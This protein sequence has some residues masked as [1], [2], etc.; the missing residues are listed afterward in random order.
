LCTFDLNW[1]VGGWYKQ[2]ERRFAGC[3]GGRLSALRYAFRDP[4]GQI[5]L[6][7]FSSNSHKIVILR[8]SDYFVLFVFSAYSTSCIQVPRQS[9]HPERSALQI[10]R[11]QRALCAESKDPGDACLQML[12]GAFRP[13]TTTQD[14]K[15]TTSERNAARIY[16]VTQRLWRGVEGPVLSVA[17]GTSKVLNYPCC[18]FG[19]FSSKL[20][21]SRHAER[22]LIYPCRS[23]LF[24]HRGPPVS[25]P[26]VENAKKY[27]RT[28]QVRVAAESCC[29]V[30][31]VETLR[32]AWGN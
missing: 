20:P 32:A 2:E 3:G 25:F 10:Y 23:E 8:A 28:I 12:S 30:S 26:G 24:N 7:C 4:I 15:V 19:C 9:R 21:Q 22:S 16:R 18:S 6:E 17:E 1:V 13:Q 14:K 27:P 29:R 11:K 31:V 5:C